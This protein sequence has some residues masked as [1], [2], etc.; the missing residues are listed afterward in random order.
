MSSTRSFL[1]TLSFLVLALHT[2]LPHSTAQE[3]L[4]D[5]KPVTDSLD[6]VEDIDSSKAYKTVFDEFYSSEPIQLRIE[7]DIS[8][9]I[10]KKVESKDVDAVLSWT[11]K[12]QSVERYAVEIEARGK[13][14]KKICSFPPIKIKFR[15][16][17]LKEKGLTSSFRT[18][19]LVT[20]C[21]DNGRGERSLLKEYL[22]YKM[23]NEITDLSFR[24]QL[25]KIEYVDTG[26]KEKSI[27]RFG[28]LIENKDE[29]AYRH[30]GKISP[31][32]NFDCKQLDKEAYCQMLVFQ[33]MIGN[34]DWRIKFLHNIKLIKLFKDSLYL[35]VPYDFDYSGLVN[36]SY[37]ISNPDLPTTN[38]IE[39]F[40]MGDSSHAPEH[41]K[42]TL[43]LYRQKRAA[44]LAL[45]EES[46][47]I[48][49]KDRK[50]M[51]RYINSFYRA[52]RNDRIAA[53]HL[54]PWDW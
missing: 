50:Y 54:S 9:M 30:E 37:A 44:I 22:A 36:T 12:D 17:D 14:R 39:R 10:K 49:K 27:T 19:K 24:V 47:L 7:G 2:F 5:A 46:K 53:I 26:E 33:Y 8:K 43:H 45:S 1:I 18:Y 29:L 25:A 15:P 6:L 23:Y 52:I 4:E 48:G 3:V 31:S 42:A 40:F 11:K 35:P 21:F 20:H 34:Q 41:M 13:S 38:H 32:Y 51:K 28:F 16:E